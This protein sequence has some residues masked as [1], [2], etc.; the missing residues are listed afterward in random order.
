MVCNMEEWEREGLHGYYGL[1]TSILHV[2]YF[3]RKSGV[4]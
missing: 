1:F 2:L 4:T 3:V